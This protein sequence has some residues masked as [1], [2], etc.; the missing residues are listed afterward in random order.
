MPAVSIL[1]RININDC[2]YVFQKNIL[3]LITFKKKHLITSISLAIVILKVKQSF[4][5][6]LEKINPGTRRK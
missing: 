2:F 6:H 3:I 1:M 5:L 4:T